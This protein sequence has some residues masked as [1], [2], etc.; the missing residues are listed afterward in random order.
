[1]R[2]NKKKLGCCGYDEL[3]YKP[4]TTRPLLATDLSVRREQNERRG[5]FGAGILFP[6][7]NLNQI[8]G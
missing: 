8:R 5:G 4:P 2:K 7:S 6:I 3:A 1:M